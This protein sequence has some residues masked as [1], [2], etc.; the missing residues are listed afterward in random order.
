MSLRSAPADAGLVGSSTN[1]AIFSL[2]F[3]YFAY[4]WRERG[5]LEEYDGPDTW[6]R[7]L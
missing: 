6:Q 2:G 7:E 3:V 1:S 5:P 4:P